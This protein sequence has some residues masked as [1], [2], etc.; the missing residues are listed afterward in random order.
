MPTQPC[1]PLVHTCESHCECLR[2][3]QIPMPYSRKS[4]SHQRHG[5]KTGL[6]TSKLYIRNVATEGAGRRAGLA[7]RNQGTDLILLT[8]GKLAE[9]WS[10]HGFWR[11]NSCPK[12]MGEWGKL[13]EKK[14]KKGR[15]KEGLEKP[16]SPGEQ[17]K[18]PAVETRNTVPQ[19]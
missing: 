12:E 1:E 10:Q 17:D 19:I 15:G 3:V 2:T 4:D 16:C 5:R 9:F 8:A 14:K 18:V 6:Q 11:Q 7:V 13:R